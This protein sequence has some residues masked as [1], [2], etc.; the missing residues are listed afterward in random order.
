[1]KKIILLLG[2]SFMMLSSCKKNLPDVGST[3]AEKV[4][5]EWWIQIYDGT[6]LLSPTHFHFATYNTA[7]NDNTIWIDDFEGLW[8]MKFKATVDYSN[9]T[10]TA[11]NSKNEY[12]PGPPQGTVK[13]TEGKI[14]LGAAHSKT[15]N[16]TDSIYF[17]AEFSDD[18]GNVYT[19]GGH[20]R[21]RFSEDEY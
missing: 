16:V 10:F 6:T 12:M 20:A 11:N 4:A 21:T 7:A 3:A 14:L 9:L 8:P 1:M 15:G 13:L 18:P 2:V 17:K 19:F 5:N